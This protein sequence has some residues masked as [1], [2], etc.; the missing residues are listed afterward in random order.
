MLRVRVQ[1][2]ITDARFRTAVATGANAQMPVKLYE[3]CGVPCVARSPIMLT[4]CSKAPL[5][6]ACGPLC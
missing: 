6:P 1:T 5:T 3:T 4:T 2:N